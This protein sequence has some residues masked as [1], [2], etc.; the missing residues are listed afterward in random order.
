MANTIPAIQTYLT[1]ILDEV[2]KNAS[3][4]S[5]LDIDSQL[6]RAVRETPGTVLIP[7]ISF[8]GGLADYNKSTG[9]VAGD[10]T[11]GWQA[12]T[13][14]NDRAR[15]FTID[16]VENLESAGVALANVA[17]QFL[18]THVVP[19]IDAYRFAKYAT[20]AGARATATLT[21]TTV[22]AAIATALQTLL[23]AEVPQEDLVLFMSNSA[24]ALL[25]EAV[26]S[27]RLVTGES[28]TLGIANYDGLPVFTVPS[29]RFATTATLT[30]TG[31]FT[32]A[33]NYINFLL[34]DKNSAVQCIKHVG[35][36][37]FTPDQNII[38][39]GYLWRYRIYHDAFIPTNKVNGI[40][41]HLGSAIA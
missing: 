1:G 11:V 22:E 20:G 23:D 24:Y 30:S 34:M 10:V 29:G 17:S 16:A 35:E 27:Y 28:V 12:F 36:K 14:A 21:A 19:E 13:L 40:Y 31:G 2:Y 37:L 8:S 6:V 18:R 38:T 7:S 25:K 3:K 5:V 39:D 15:Q 33:G 9:A 4:S 32:L 41:A 26:A